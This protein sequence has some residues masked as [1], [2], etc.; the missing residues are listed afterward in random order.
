MPQQD[1][2]AIKF[3]MS[4]WIIEWKDRNRVCTWLIN[5]GRL[6]YAEPN[7][8]NILLILQ[9]MNREGIVE[10]AFVLIRIQCEWHALYSYQILQFFS[11]VK[12]KAQFKVQKYDVLFSPMTQLGKIH[13]RVAQKQ[14]EIT[15]FNIYSVIKF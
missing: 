7:N 1:L 14:P 10:T 5:A 2:V 9:F 11:F 3:I 6:D 8:Q 12:I 15:R 13:E 4:A